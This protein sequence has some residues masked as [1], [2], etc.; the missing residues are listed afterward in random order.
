MTSYFWGCEISPGFYFSTKRPPN[1]L[2][3]WISTVFLGWRW[4]RFQEKPGR[5]PCTVSFAGS[6]DIAPMTADTF[7]EERESWQSES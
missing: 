5:V 1:M 3:R 4:Q 6:W 2:R 7:Y